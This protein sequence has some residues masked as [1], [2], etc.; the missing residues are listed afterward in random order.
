LISATKGT[1]QKSLVSSSLILVSA[2]AKQRDAYTVTSLTATQLRGITWDILNMYST[3]SYLHGFFDPYEK[4]DPFKCTS[5]GVA[6]LRFT[7]SDT[8]RNIT[9]LQHFSEVTKEE[10]DFLL[11]V[12][13]EERLNT[14]HGANRP[15][16]PNAVPERYKQKIKATTEL[17]NY[18]LGK[19]DP[20]V[21]KRSVRYADVKS[22]ADNA[23]EAARQV[24][25]AKQKDSKEKTD[26]EKSEKVQVRERSKSMPEK[27]RRTSFAELME[28][29]S[30]AKPV[31]KR[32]ETAKAPV[33]QAERSL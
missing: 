33:K 27:P 2:V 4:G 7:E 32:A 5:V 29:E 30:P 31:R 28:E 20:D 11:L 12:T 15:G 18:A 26:G 19:G 9:Q 17:F 14:K 23:H 10:R 21:V 25:I 8:Y 3:N 24:R 16:E 1:Y 13:E 6:A 22:K